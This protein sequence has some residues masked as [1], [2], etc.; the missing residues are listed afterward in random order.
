MK[1]A[2]QAGVE[3]DVKCSHLQEDVTASPSYYTILTFLSP[4]IMDSLQ[5][6]REAGLLTFWADMA[7]SLFKHT[8]LLG[9]RERLRKTDD[10][11]YIELIHFKGLLS[12]CG[13]IISLAV[14]SLI[15]ELIVSGDLL[16][17]WGN[18]RIS[19]VRGV[20]YWR[21]FVGNLRWNGKTLF[22]NVFRKGDF[23]KIF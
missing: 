16:K 15:I 22:N 8:S 12:V 23:V 7:E 6:M 14:V 2:F 5:G 20:K 19:V 4:Q 13:G 17:L 1:S 10:I 9:E 18:V 11:A 3:L 21:R